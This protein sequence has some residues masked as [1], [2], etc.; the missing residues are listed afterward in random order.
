[1]PQGDLTTRGWGPFESIDMANAMGIEPIITL[2]SSESY[3]DLG[4]LVGYVGTNDGS[5][6]RPTAHD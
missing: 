3:S 6:P 4:D 1:M 2:H 5:P